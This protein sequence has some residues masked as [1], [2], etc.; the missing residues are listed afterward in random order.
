[1]NQL[2]VYCH[3]NPKSFCSAIK[4]RV[5]ETYSSLGDLVVV[6]D[7]YAIGFDPV[8]KPAD[9]EALQQGHVLED[10]KMEQD[11]IRWCDVMTF[12]YPIWWTGLPAMVK[13]YIDR[14]LSYGFAYAIDENHNISQLL[15]G[16]KAIILNTMGT[17]KEFYDQSGMTKSLQMTTDTGIFEFCGVQVLAHT[18]FGA[19]PHVGNDVRLA[20]L[21]D[22]ARLVRKATGR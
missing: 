18:F 14:V 1:M 7:L 3:P 10:V 16:K 11:H 22:A 4:Q 17:P 19:V 12:I 20:M 8:L 2:I 13:G 21:E 6:R 15:R 9:F 5:S